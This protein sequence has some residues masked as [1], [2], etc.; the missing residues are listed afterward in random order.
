[1]VGGPSVDP[2]AGNSTTTAAST[3]D[4]GEVATTS[5]TT[6]TSGTADVTS[7]SEPA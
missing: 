1:M 3:S 7:T 6:S 2:G 5:A 4:V